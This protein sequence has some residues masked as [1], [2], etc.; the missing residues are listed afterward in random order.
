[1]PVEPEDL[2][3]PRIEE[4]AVP[5]PYVDDEQE[6]VGGGWWSW[7]SWIPEMF[8]EESHTGSLMFGVGFNSDAGCWSIHHNEQNYQTCPAAISPDA[9]MP[10]VNEEDCNYEE[11]R[12]CRCPVE[13]NGA[14]ELGSDCMVDEVPNCQEDPCYHRQ[15]PGCPYTGPYTPPSV[16]PNQP[17]PA[18]ATPSKPGKVKQLLLNW[19]DCTQ[20]CPD[21]RSLDTMEYRPSDGRPDLSMFFPF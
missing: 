4:D 21:P 20:Q 17:M 2:V 12:G 3:M 11:G 15:Y 19:P 7:F 9:T 18:P 14:V 6:S 13:L 8:A 5:M 10:Y 16:Y 1:V